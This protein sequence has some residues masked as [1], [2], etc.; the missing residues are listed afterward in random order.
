MVKIKQIRHGIAESLSRVQRLSTTLNPTGAVSEGRTFFFVCLA[1]PHSSYFAHTGFNV[2]QRHLS[3]A[4]AESPAPAA[5]T[6]ESATIFPLSPSQQAVVF[7]ASTFVLCSM[8]SVIHFSLPVLYFPSS[9]PPS[10]LR[11]PL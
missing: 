7:H 1:S 2:T 9:L 11:F 4:D 10:F 6:R 3:A 5:A 8:R